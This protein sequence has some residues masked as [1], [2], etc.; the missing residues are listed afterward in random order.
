[1]GNRRR[2]LLILIFV[3]A[4]TAASAFAITQKRTVLGL[5]LRG[6]TELV[7][8]ARPTPQNPTVDAGD[9]DRAQRYLAARVARRSQRIRR[10][11]ELAMT[12]RTPPR[13]ST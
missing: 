11:L 12:R 5:D 1:M 13:R 3:V 4:L 7:Y 9:M 2:N 6:G 10:W 8:Q